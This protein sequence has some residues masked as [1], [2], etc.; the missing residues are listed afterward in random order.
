MGEICFRYFSAASLWRS[1]PDIFHSLRARDGDAT[2]VGGRR[3]LVLFVRRGVVA[4][5]FLRSAA[6][7][8]DLRVRA[9]AYAC[10]LGV[11]NGWS[12]ESVPRWS[13]RRTRGD[14]QSKLLDRA[15]AV[16]LSDLQHSDDRRLRRAQPFSKRA[17]VWATALRRDWR[18]VGVPF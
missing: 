17:A 7:N 8:L 5:R 11:V 10:A 18:H 6:S 1:Y 4:D 3:I 15:G 13:R 12:R 9:R 14:H 2:A 16:F